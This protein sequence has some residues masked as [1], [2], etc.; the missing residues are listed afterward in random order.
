MPGVPPP[1]GLNID[2]CIIIIII[3]INLLG[4]NRQNAWLHPRIFYSSKSVYI[5][6]EGYSKNI[7]QISFVFLASNAIYSIQFFCFI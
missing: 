3:I 5:V 4:L 2:R 6:H 7:E 1:L